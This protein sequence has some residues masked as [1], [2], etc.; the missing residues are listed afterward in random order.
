MECKC[1]KC[2]GN[3]KVCIKSEPRQVLREAPGYA[4]ELLKT[5]LKEG[6]SGGWIK[7]SPLD[8]E[9][10]IFIDYVSQYKKKA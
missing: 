8:C 10:I 5:I 3:A 9:L 7:G 4:V 1:V 6:R 2:G